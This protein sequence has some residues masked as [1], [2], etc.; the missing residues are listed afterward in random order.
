MTTRTTSTRLA[1]QSVEHPPDVRRVYERIL[2]DAKVGHRFIQTGSRVRVHLVEAGDGP[3]VVL[4][5]G[6]GTSSL[7]HL[8]FVTQ[9]EG[10]RAINVDRPGY[11][12]SDP[13]NVP[14]GRYREAAVRFVDEVLD[15]LGLESTAV[16]GA[17][18]GGLWALWYAIAH[19]RRVRRLILLTGT[20]LL[21]G[22]RFPMP[23][24]VVVAP[25]VGDLLARV[26]PS[27]AMVVRFMA[28]M[29]EKDTIVR[30]PEV[31]DSLV[32][33]GRDPVAAATALAEYRAVGTPFGF[34]SSLRVQ[35]ADLRSL[36]APTLMI[37]GD[38]E[39]MGASE[40]AQV[41]ANL[42]P[43]V[44]LEVL[45]GGHV[46]WLGNSQSVAQLVSTFVR[47]ERELHDDGSPAEPPGAS[48][49]TGD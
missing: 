1:A 22:T 42:I 41:T 48:G 7:S 32:A 24:P 13:V 10:V 29:G 34:R 17:S 45:P 20:P 36:S 44:R 4:F 39:P 49:G 31:I 6:G 8:P 35:P 28:A 37:W 21:P 27:A 15:A 5:H 12:L 18:G 30:H 25:F 40:V 47:S 19:P 38:R 16:G 14:H 9:L 26:K 2:A 23:L 46:P 43:N 3:P 11:G 33:A